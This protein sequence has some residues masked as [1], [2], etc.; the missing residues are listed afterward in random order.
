MGP[1]ETE[2]AIHFDWAQNPG[3]GIPMHELMSRGVREFY[4]V[5]A[6]PH[7]PVLAHVDRAYIML[8]ILVRAILRCV[9]NRSDF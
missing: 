8:R 6:N 3:H 9:S 2:G 4:S 7:D 5:V 1:R